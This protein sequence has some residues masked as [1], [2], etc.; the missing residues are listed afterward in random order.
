MLRPV[1]E[2]VSLMMR[3]ASLCVIPEKVALFSGII[4]RSTIIPTKGMLFLL[5]PDSNGESSSIFDIMH[6]FIVLV[7]AALL[8]FFFK[9]DAFLFFSFLKC[10]PS[11]PVGNEIVISDGSI[12]SLGDGA[13]V[14]IFLKINV[15]QS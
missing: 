2:S 12:V 13:W 15:R 6:T 14:L 7:V 11:L 9:I 3:A 4:I 5:S 8:P 10:I 1:I